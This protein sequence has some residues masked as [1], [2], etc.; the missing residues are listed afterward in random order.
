MSED[1][2]GVTNCCCKSVC[3]DDEDEV[4]LLDD[5]SAG[6]IPAVETVDE[7]ETTPVEA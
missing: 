2:E 6:E 3:D 4:A 5:A 1:D 7:A